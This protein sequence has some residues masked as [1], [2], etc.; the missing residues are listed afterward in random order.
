MSG[1]EAAGLALAFLPLLIAAVK[2]Y[3]DCLRPFLDYKHFAKEADRY[4]QQLSVQKT[5][6]RG[7]CLILLKQ[8]VEHDAA[9]SMLRAADNPAWS[10][11]VLES[12]ISQMLGESKEACI[13]TVVMIEEN[14]REI[15]SENQGLWTAI[16][17]DH[18]VTAPPIA[19]SDVVPV[20][21]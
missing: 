17:E 21:E 15:E 5:I 4:R 19:S 9:S 8:V 16:D 3:D 14:L 2:H 1:I 18:Q 7:H 13:T 12:Q 6:F 10:D 20:D 11:G